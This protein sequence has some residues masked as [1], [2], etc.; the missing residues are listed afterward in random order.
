MKYL[1]EELAQFTLCDPQVTPE[2][3][4]DIVDAMITEGRPQEFT[5]EKLEKKKLL[6]DQ[7]MSNCITQWDKGCGRF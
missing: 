6:L 2:V 7:Y 4:E 3:K 5:P 1:S